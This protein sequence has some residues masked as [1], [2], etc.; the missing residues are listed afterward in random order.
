[1]EALQTLA[2][3]NVKI[4]EA[5]GVLSTLKAE[6]SQFLTER[7][8]KALKKVEDILKESEDVL[9]EAFSNYEELK[10]FASDAAAF[11]KFLMEAFEDFTKLRKLHEEYTKAWEIRTHEVRKELDKVKNQNKAE[12]AQINAD[13]EAIDKAWKKIT[14]AKLKIKSDR[15]SIDAAIIRLKEN[16]V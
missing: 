10:S 1:M 3:T 6:E 12:K 14:E 7:E 8:E 4:G 16:R 15:Q 2:D 9:Q 13:R 5:R 11:C